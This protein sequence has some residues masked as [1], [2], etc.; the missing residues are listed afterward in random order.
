L[1]WQG[2]DA[3]LPSD[4]EHEAESRQASERFF[5]LLTERQGPIPGHFHQRV[6]AD[7]RLGL[8]PSP[9]QG[10]LRVALN[11]RRTTRLFDQTVALDRDVFSSILQV[12][13]GCQGIGRLSEQV[14]ALK[15]TSPSGGAMHPVEAYPLVLSVDGLDPGIYHYHVGDHALEPLQPCSEA[16]GREMARQFT[17]GQ[18]YYA[19]AQVLF[20]YTARFE[21]S[22]WKYRRNPRAY[23]VAQLDLGHLSQTLYLLCADLGLGAFFTAACNESDIERALAVD[24]IGE[25][26][27]AVGGMGIP[28]PDAD[29]MGFRSEPYAPPGG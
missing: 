20:L 17:A 27:L 19:T 9:Y 14:L 1:K 12:V 2:R 7:K 3:G 8:V 5:E 16:E 26:A 25:A 23:K 24:G 10:D 4:T 11:N 21:R 6:T 18:D 22:F 13:F 28:A 15:K 29:A